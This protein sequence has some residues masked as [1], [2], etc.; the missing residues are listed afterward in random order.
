M[1]SG[2]GESD[3][4]RVVLREQ[5]FATAEKVRDVITE[6]YRQLKQRRVDVQRK[7]TL[8]LANKDTEYIL[9]KPMKVC[10]VSE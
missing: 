6:T 8:Y 1:S 4:I 3:G 9:F 2:S 10:L 5:P 7:M